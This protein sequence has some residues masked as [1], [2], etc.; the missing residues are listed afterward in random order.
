[1]FFINK[2]FGLYS[3]TLI[4]P[5]NSE[6]IIDRTPTLYYNASDDEDDSLVYEVNITCIG[7]CSA[8]NRYY[9]NVSEN[10]TIPS[11][12]GY[13]Y[14]NGYY[15]KW[16]VR[17]CENETS[18]LYCSGWLSR[19]FNLSSYVEINL[20]SVNLN[21]G[22]LYPGD[23]RNTTNIS[24][25]PVG[26]SN[27]GNCM[28][29]VSVNATNLWDLISEPSDYFMMKSRNNTGNSTWSNM[30]WFQL[31]PITGSAVLVEGLNHGLGNNS[32]SVDVSA[33]VPLGEYSGSKVANI[34]FK[35]RLGE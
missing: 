5:N 12:L 23:E 7:G 9:A 24:L 25:S 1:M 16:S 29:N 20:S 15:Y 31:P 17:A 33:K 34:N 26:L 30:S 28:I 21:F 8:D 10:Y 27:L 11:E 22:N 19:T 14:D 13:L 6:I 35:A 4:N 18:D 2:C 32:I 3:L